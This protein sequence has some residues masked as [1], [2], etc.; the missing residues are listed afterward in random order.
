[1]NCQEIK[2]ILPDYTVDNIS[3]SVRQ[4]IVSHL[5]ECSDCTRELELLRRTAFL[6]NT[7]PLSEPPAG[8]W[9]NIAVQLKENNQGRVNPIT[10]W[11]NPLDWIKI[12]PIPVFAS[13]AV[14]C[15]ILGGLWLHQGS[16]P[17]PPPMQAKATEEPIESYITQHNA[18]SL[19]DPAT[20]KNGAGLLLV[21]AEE[22]NK[23]K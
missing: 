11:W 18:V 10:V 6:V 23:D 2:K 13:A 12:K 16:I 7:I 9:N 5:A 15:L 14:V 19:E 3:E 4:M 20:D 1:M 8:L 21:S 17:T 22:V